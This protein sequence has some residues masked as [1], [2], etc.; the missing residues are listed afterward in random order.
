MKDYFNIE[1]GYRYEPSKEIAKILLSNNSVQKINIFDKY[2]YKSL[3]S[4]IPRALYNYL[5]G[6]LK[7]RIG[8]NYD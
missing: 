5:V 8:I 1:Y 7:L 4:I 2:L 6:L 3:I